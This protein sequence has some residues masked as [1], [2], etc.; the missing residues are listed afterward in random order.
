MDSVM[1]RVM[2]KAKNNRAISQGIRDYEIAEIENKFAVRVRLIEKRTQRR[3]ADIHVAIYHIEQKLSYERMMNQRFRELDKLAKFTFV[4]MPN[5]HATDDQY[6]QEYRDTYETLKF[7]EI[8][9]SDSYDKVM[10]GLKFYWED[11]TV[12]D[13]LM[14]LIG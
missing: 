14:A 3:D 7:K 13:E 2:A 9:E 6:V 10:H 12:R 5:R 1:K 4:T 8:V 11:K